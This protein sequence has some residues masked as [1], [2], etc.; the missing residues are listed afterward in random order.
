MEFNRKKLS[1]KLDIYIFQNTV[2]YYSKIS[3][4]NA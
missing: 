1:N 3:D 2:H 4:Q